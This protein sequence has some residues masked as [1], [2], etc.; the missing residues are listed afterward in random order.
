MIEYG[1]YKECATKSGRGHSKRK[2]CR[3]T[4]PRCDDKR[5]VEERHASK[6]AFNVLCKACKAAICRVSLK[7]DW[8]GSDFQRLK[9]HL[10]NSSSGFVFCQRSCKDAAGSSKESKFNN[11]VPNHYHTSKRIS[12][13]NATPFQK[14]KILIE[15][16]PESTLECRICNT[17]FSSISRSPT[18]WYCTQECFKN[19]QEE[20]FEK[21]KQPSQPCPASFLDR[22]GHLLPRIAKKV[23]AYYNWT[24]NAKLEDESRCGWSRIHPIT[25]KI[26]VQLDHIDGDSLNNEFSNLRVMCPSCHSLTSTFGA[27]NVGNGRAKMKQ[28]YHKNNNFIDKA[29]VETLRTTNLAP[30]T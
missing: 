8:C 21:W 4:C 25:N 16:F 9:S 23:K 30:L 14:N 28:A 5:L 2:A 10:K 3:V 13:H 11:M 24:C 18:A 7:C 20:L 17:L 6:K 29:N 27:L 1:F 19:W 22:N 12:G 15:R 26:P